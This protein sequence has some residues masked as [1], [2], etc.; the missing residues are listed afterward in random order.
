MTRSLRR[1]QWVSM[2][3]SLS[4]SKRL[5]FV[6]SLLVLS[7][8]GACGQVQSFGDD[9]SAGAGAS[10]PDPD[11]CACKVDGDLCAFTGS[12]D[13]DA[14]ACY[15]PGVTCDPLNACPT[16][17]AC[18]EDTGSARCVCT[19]PLVCGVVCSDSS[20]CPKEYACDPEAGV[21]RWPVSCFSDL[22]CPAGQLCLADATQWAMLCSPAGSKA[23]GESCSDS[24]ECASGICTSG[25]CLAACKSTGDCAP[26]LTC[27]ESHPDYAEETDLGLPRLGCRADSS[28]G[29][30]AGDEFCFVDECLP[31]P[32]DTSANCGGNSCVLDIRTFNQCATADLGCASN[33]VLL[34][35]DE[36]ATLVPDHCVIHTTCWSD[37]SCPAP[38][39]CIDVSEVL[40]EGE[41]E[42]GGLTQVCGRALPPNVEE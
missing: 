20:D 19:D 38:Y 14:S 8:L 34:F 35:A 29:S 1:S 7:A 42:T 24:H 17:Y 23:G 39:K 31:A 32:C 28:C 6:T 9:D 11:A 40:V 37:A 25:L 15:K 26:G 4:T 18:E 10:G 3:Q 36:T 12:D 22:N 41:F 21:C 2:G 33:E 27:A 30:C 16:N 13:I 5:T